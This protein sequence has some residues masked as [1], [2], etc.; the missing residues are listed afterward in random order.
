MFTVISRNTCATTPSVGPCP[1]FDPLTFFSCSSMPGRIMMIETIVPSS[2]RKEKASRL[3][4]EL[5]AD[6]Q[7]D[8]RRQEAE[9]HRQEAWRGRGRGR[10]VRP[11]QTA[12]QEEGGRAST[13]S[14][15]QIV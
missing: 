4:V 8:D 9:P 6:G 15:R 3:T 13:G 5:Y 7:Q 2:S 12:P 1:T 10:G 14:Q 11:H